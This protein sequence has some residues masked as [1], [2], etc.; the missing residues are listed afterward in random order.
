MSVIINNTVSN[1]S[2]LP[3]VKQNGYHIKLTTDGSW[4]LASLIGAQYVFG[5][6]INQFHAYG[7][8][9]SD[10]ISKLAKVCSGKKHHPKARKRCLGLW[11]DVGPEHQFP[12]FSQYRR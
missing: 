2:F 8:S 3:W 11:I 6:R 10:A 9:P 4:T 12:I 7:C 5:N 1:E